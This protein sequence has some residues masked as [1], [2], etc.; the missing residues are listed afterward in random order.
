MPE[1]TPKATRFYYEEKTDE[2]PAVWNIELRLVPGQ[3]LL[4]GP[5][6]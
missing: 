2:K 4:K 1:M 6:R 5:N 3:I